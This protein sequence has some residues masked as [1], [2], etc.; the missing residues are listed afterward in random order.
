MSYIL[1]IFSE[2][3]LDCKT[4]ASI[5][6]FWI[7]TAYSYARNGCFVLTKSLQLLDRNISVSLSD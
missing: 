5:Y 7:K 2:Y 6:N 4:I 1:L 3:G